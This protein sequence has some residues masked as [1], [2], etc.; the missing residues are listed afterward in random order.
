V[1]VKEKVIIELDSSDSDTP[2]VADLEEKKEQPNTL[3]KSKLSSFY[4]RIKDNESKIVT[5]KHLVR[6][7]PFYS[8]T[9]DSSLP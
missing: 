3:S 5:Y 4:S 8:R 9:K 1:A 2:K 7:L 6:S